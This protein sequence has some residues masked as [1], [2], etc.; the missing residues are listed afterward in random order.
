MWYVHSILL[1][2]S[3]SLIFLTD[4]LH[5]MMQDFLARSLYSELKQ[6]GVHVQCQIP[7]FVTTKLSKLR[8]SS[9]FT[10]TPEKW[11]QSAVKNIGYASVTVP[12][13]PHRIQDWFVR[14]VPTWMLRT[15]LISMHLRLREKYLKKL[16]SKKNE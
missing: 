10:P 6:F 1:S 4:V 2:I 3:E 14:S 15:Q 11:A 12:Y 13:W 9:F 16:N 5:L 7:Y 8:H